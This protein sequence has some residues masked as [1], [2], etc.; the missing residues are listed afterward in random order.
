MSSAAVCKYHRLKNKQ[1]CILER[2][3]VKFGSCNGS[4]NK[5]APDDMVGG[6]L[7]SREKLGRPHG[8]S[9]YRSK[10]GTHTDAAASA[11]GPIHSSSCS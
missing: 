6:V 1:I 4:P 9:K 8:N 7:L 2:C 3:F 11:Q 5:N 10:G